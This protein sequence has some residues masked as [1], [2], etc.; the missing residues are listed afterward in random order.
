M[1]ALC[2]GHK[3]CVSPCTLGHTDA[4]GQRRRHSHGAV[5]AGAQARWSGKWVPSALAARYQQSI[6]KLSATKCMWNACRTPVAARQNGCT[7]RRAGAAQEEGGRSCCRCY[8][9]CC[10][11][12][13]RCRRCYRGY[14][15]RCCGYCCH[16][17]GRHTHRCVLAQVCACFRPFRLLVSPPPQ[18]KK[19]E[20]KDS[21][22][23]NTTPCTSECVCVLYPAPCQLQECLPGLPSPAAR[24][25]QQTP[26]AV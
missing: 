15:R 3:R 26:P 22:D 8:R 14:S 16:H 10:R 24:A 19:K 9:C 2:G 23:K 13:R 18:K 21:N 7:E 12:C 17:E 20:S 6:V 1:H 4:A 11:R 25:V 5:G